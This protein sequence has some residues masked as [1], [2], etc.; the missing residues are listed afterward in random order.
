MHAI[1]KKGLLM[2]MMTRAKKTTRLVS[3]FLLYNPLCYA[4]GL[5]LFSLKLGL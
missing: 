1:R 3:Y 5:H 4:N 2:Q